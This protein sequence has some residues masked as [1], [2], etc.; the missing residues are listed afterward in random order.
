M[1]G[2]ETKDMLNNLVLFHILF[3]FIIFMNKFESQNKYFFL[4]VILLS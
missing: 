2:L 3:K 1:K 4:M